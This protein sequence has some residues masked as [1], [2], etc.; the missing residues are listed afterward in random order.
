M[1]YNLPLW[2]QLHLMLSNDIAKMA[3]TICLLE[4]SGFFFLLEI[5]ILVS[6]RN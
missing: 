6:R 3:D 2:L 4:I 1:L 5:E